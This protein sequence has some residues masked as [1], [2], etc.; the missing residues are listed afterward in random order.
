LKTLVM[1]ARNSARVLAAAAGLLT[2]GLPDAGAAERACAAITI[3]ADPAFAGRFPDLLARVREEL[4]ARNDLD[5]CARVELRLE[6]D[7]GIVLFVS[8]PDGRAAS[9][10]VRRA[11]DVLPSLQALLVVPEPTARSSEEPL[12]RSTPVSSTSRPP[13]AVKPRFRLKP[14]ELD[15]DRLPASPMAPRSVGVELSA[16][17]GVR[18]GDGQFGY[19]MGVLSFL[20]VKS[21]LIGAQ[22]RV[23]GYRSILGSDPAT[24]LEL[25]LLAGRR[26]DFG[27]TALDLTAGP[28][29]AMKGIA[30][31]DR[32]AVSVQQQ[33]FPAAMR[34]PPHSEPSSGPVPRFLAGA[35]LGFSPRSLFRSFVALELDVGRTRSFESIA[36]TDASLTTR[37]PSFTLG[38]AVGAT[39]GTP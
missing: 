10:S 12:P 32:Q 24:A 17:G 27:S 2:F 26:F 15:A 35:R 14:R 39:V 4:S 21:W 36:D 8:L 38:L 29:V 5:S 31:S 23:D 7:P 19:G 28:G 11:E 3:G 16:L 33:Q 34:P 13:A 20:E 37:M 1:R 25:S 22:G 6:R 30:F 18:A 9:R